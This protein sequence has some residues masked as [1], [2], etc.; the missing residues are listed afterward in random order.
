MDAWSGGSDSTAISERTFRAGA[1]RRVGFSSQAMPQLPRP[2]RRRRAARAGVGSSRR[3]AYARSTHPPGDPGRRQ[4]AGLRQEP[5]SRRRPLLWWRFSR[6]CTRL[7]SRRRKTLPERPG[8]SGMNSRRVAGLSTGLFIV[9]VAVGSPL[10]ALDH[11][12]LT[13]HMLQH[14]LLMTVA[15]PLILLAA[16]AIPLP[17]AVTHVMTHPVI[18][19]LASTATVIGWH[20]PALFALGM[21][22]Q[23]WHIIETASF[24]VAGVLFWLPVIQAW[25][26]LAT[27]PRWSV[28]LYLFLATLP[29]DALSAFLAF[30]GRVVLSALPLRTWAVRCFSSRRPGDGGR[31]DVDLGNLCLSG[32][33]RRR[34]SP[35][36]FA[37]QA[38]V[39]GG[40]RLIKNGY[41][42]QRI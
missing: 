32:S 24:F 18:C 28:P 29:C 20:I 36:A 6:L 3:A 2:G 9:W 17:R 26:S 40:S 35:N 37:Q 11:Q 25:P 30:C 14:L 10:A 4:H 21:H 27:C 12:M 41:R 33:R 39:E 23:T 8:R 16:P 42:Y 13:F 7:D 22:S 1:A 15:A 34:H 19:W 38:S 31:P 5:E